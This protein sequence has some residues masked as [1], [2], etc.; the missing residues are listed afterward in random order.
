MPKLVKPDPYCAF[1][2]DHER[3]L[4]LVSRDVRLSLIAVIVMLSPDLRTFIA[5][6]L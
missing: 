3:R 1:K 4:A 2:N 6:W 5:W